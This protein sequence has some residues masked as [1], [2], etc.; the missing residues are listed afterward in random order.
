MITS[1]TLTVIVL[2][3]F[4]GPSL[5]F[6]IALTASIPTDFWIYPYFVILSNQEEPTGN[7]T[8]GILP[9]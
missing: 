9:G 3:I 5:V 7:S 1:I 8:V 6:V 2:N 4:L